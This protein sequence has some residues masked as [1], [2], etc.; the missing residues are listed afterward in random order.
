MLVS[1]IVRRN[2]EYFADA[3][4]VVVPGRSAISWAALE[5]RTNRL[6]RVLIRLGLAKGDRI[7]MFAP[8]CAEY[9]DFF[10]SCAKTGVIGAALN[11]R[12][13]AQDLVPYLRYVEPGALIVHADLAQQAREWIDQVPSITH[14]LGIGEGHGFDLDLEVLIAAEEPTD[15]AIS[16][17]DFDMYQLVATSGTTGVPK[18]AILTHRNAVSA[19]VSWMSEVP[20]PERS[21]YLQTIPMFFNSGGPAGVHPVLMKGGRAVV[22]PAF[23]PALF[24]RA[25]PEH[26]VTHSILVPTM[27]QMVLSQP[28]CEEFDL[29]TIRGITCGGSP[30]PKA[31]L[32]RAKRVIGD[33]FFPM[34]GM[35]ETYSC[36]LLLRPEVQFTSGTD[37]QVRRLGSAGKPHIL[38]QVRVADDAGAEV[39]HDNAS[40]GEIWLQGD[41]VSPG[42]FRMPEETEASREGAWFKTGDLAVIDDEGYVTV[43]DR[44]KD[45]IITGGINVF[46]SEVEASLMEHDSVQAVAVI[47]IP[48]EQWGEAIHAIVVL[49]PGCAATEEEILDF[50]RGR[51]AGY[52]RPRSVEI[53]DELPL[54]GTGKVLKKELRAQYWT[55]T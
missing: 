20:M 54:S 13:P 50:A 42:Y 18:G 31:L 26:Q 41:S 47:G 17:D 48:H 43:V 10:F 5:Q 38:M 37:E 9:F 33:V 36:G 1:D 7:A 25:V 3:E 22:Y 46:S 19:M 32:E 21:T 45:M 15:P 27:I 40:V 29:S 2:A 51:L 11:I 39:P 52:K 44:K 24:L 34:F 53:V 6:A 16:V 49:R 14:V 30:V 12:L 35:T 23:D 8:N 55:D 28:D 4:A